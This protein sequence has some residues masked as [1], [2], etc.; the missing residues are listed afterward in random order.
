MISV[1]QPTFNGAQ[2]IELNHFTDGTLKMRCRLPENPL[3]QAYGLPLTIQWKYEAEEELVALIHLVHHL[4]DHG[5]ENLY[6]DMPY[7]PNARQ[8][9]VQSED[10]VFTLKSFAKT[11]NWLNFKRVYVRDAHSRVSVALLDRVV[12]RVPDAIIENAIFQ[13]KWAF[14]SGN[15]TLFYPDEGAMKRYHDTH[16]YPKAF[17]MKTRNPN[18][19]RV[20]SL[21]INGDLDDIDGKYVLIVD[22][23]CSKGDTALRSAR[24]LRKAGAKGVALYITHCE[25]TIL[26]SE[27]INSGDVDF[28]YTSDSIFTGTHERIK[29]ITDKKH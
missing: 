23:I 10:E 27:L 20:D 26:N 7:L 21:K 2:P 18:T 9:R 3:D 29:V 11:I 16:E 4:R 6:L 5:F 22:D 8:D 13:A 19:G 25:N 14:D 17:G 1:N 15:I 28:V 12:N 24:E